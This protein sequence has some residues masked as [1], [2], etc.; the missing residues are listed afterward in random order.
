MNSKWKTENEEKFGTMRC[1]APLIKEKSNSPNTDK[2]EIRKLQINKRQKKNLEQSVVT[3]SGF[4]WK[5]FYM[6]MFYSRNHF[7]SLLVTKVLSRRME[8]GYEN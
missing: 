5:R 4:Y 6:Q 1:N 3:N 8:K 7:Y 2:R